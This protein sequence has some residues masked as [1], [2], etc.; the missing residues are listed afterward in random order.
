MCLI[1]CNGRMS[2]FGAKVLPA[3]EV[4]EASEKEIPSLQ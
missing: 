4:V 2:G 3:A 1:T